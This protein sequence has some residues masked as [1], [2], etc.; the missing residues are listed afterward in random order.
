M[1]KTLLLLAITCTLFF[2]SQA[3]ESM[4][5]GE[6]MFVEFDNSNATFQ[7]PE[8]KSWFIYNIYSDYVVGG[9]VIQYE[10]KSLLQDPDDVRIFI[11]DLDGKMKT[12]YTKNI[13]GPQVYRSTNASTVIPFP[14]NFTDKTS[15]SLIALNGVLG[16][17]TPHPGSCYISIIEVAN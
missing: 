11:K 3:Q 7:V 4:P 1:K 10:G 14:L 2:G 8:G 9:T 6:I 5:K 13:Y 12:D 17:L 16:R 15:F